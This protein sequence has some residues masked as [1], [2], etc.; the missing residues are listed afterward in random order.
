MKMKRFLSSTF[1]LLSVVFPLF[2]EVS[3]SDNLI[4]NGDF[5]LN[6]IGVGLNLTGPDGGRDEGQTFSK[7]VFY[8]VGKPAVASF[9][10][11][12]VSAESIKGGTAGGHA[13]RLDIDAGNSPADFDYGI[14]RDVGGGS[15]RPRVDPETQ[16]TLAFDLALVA[17]TG[18]STEFVATVY[19]FSDDEKEFIRTAC[20]KLG[21]A[22]RSLDDDAAFH[23]YAMNFTTSPSTTKVSVSLSPRV[24]GGNFTA[25][26]VLANVSLMPSSG[27][28][29]NTT[30]A[31]QV[32]PLVA[33]QGAAPPPKDV[34]FD[35][36]VE[37]RLSSPYGAVFRVRQ[38]EFLSIAP[39]IL[40][41]PASAEHKYHGWMAMQE[42]L[43]WETNP[44]RFGESDEADGLENSLGWLTVE[45]GWPE[46]VRSRAG[47][48]ECNTGLKA[49]DYDPFQLSYTYQH[50]KI[51]I[52]ILDRPA[53]AVMAEP[54]A[55][56]FYLGN[57]NRLKPHKNYWIAKSRYQDA[58]IFCGLVFCNPDASADNDK[59]VVADGVFICWADSIEELDELAASFS[60]VKSILESTKRWITKLTDPVQLKGD[61][62]LV[63]S[64]TAIRRGYLSMSYPFG[65][66]Y[67][68]LDEY[69]NFWVRDSSVAAVFTALS[70]IGGPLAR[71]TPYV[72]N[73]PE[74]VNEE[75][76]ESLS[77]QTFPNGQT[78]KDETDGPFY[79]ALDVYANWKLN[80]D[81]QKLKDWYPIL[82][83]AVDHVRR[84]SFDPEKH[85]FMDLWVG[86]YPACLTK[87]TRASWKEA[88]P[89][90]P[91]GPV[92][93]SSMYQNTIVCQTYLMLAEMALTLGKDE[94]SAGYLASA[95]EL[96]AAMD[97]HLWKPEKG[98]Y[99]FAIRKLADG[100]NE[101]LE[102]DY[103]C[104]GYD[105]WV[106]LTAGFPVTPDPQK[107]F[108]TV[109]F[110]MNRLFS[111]FGKPSGKAFHNAFAV[112]HAARDFILAGDFQKGRSLMN[113]AT[114]NCENQV[115]YIT[116]NKMNAFYYM[117]GVFGERLDVHVHLPFAW[118]SGVYMADVTA[119]IAPMD[120]NGITIMPTPYLKE[121][122]GLEF[123]NS[124][125]A[126]ST[127]RPESLTDK[128]SSPEPDGIV[129]DGKPVPHTM[130][131]PNA[132]LKEGASHRVTLL[133]GSKVGPVLRYTPFELVS[134]KAD[135]ECIKYRLSGYGKG[136]LRFNE[137]VKQQMIQ[138][139]D[140]CGKN[141]PFDFWT[142]EG[143]PCIGVFGRG[144]FVVSIA[145]S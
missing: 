47:N 26:V 103:T 34:L 86:E 24:V 20:L 23:R 91:E 68:G 78:F 19:E 15:G 2:G 106:S 113:I 82:C 145:S 71:W 101:E 35:K 140:S 66:T 22:D 30:M 63:K 112:A 74:P 3:E 43:G 80:G 56:R 127:E 120:F 27:S 73:N 76:K 88:W 142:S 5:E 84:I 32:A 13:V 75:G 109:D 6:E 57:K 131:I 114:E 125:F 139:R 17:T 123:R 72:M 115:P 110:M 94:E 51:T 59:S 48:L 129:L 144:P 119:L 58:D 50:G 132:L 45:T 12:I 49:I 85:L 141:M 97:K 96:A 14:N 10:G 111:N 53:I 87:E 102:Q 92:A 100:R 67:A 1:V 41:R 18:D 121:I 61:A 37:T 122:R 39:G 44:T 29:A 118:G 77:F 134:L 28:G 133:Y 126:V 46:E 65:G 69:M 99:L 81:K 116:E 31:T 108:Q 42:P 90:E 70:G 130:K 21:T 93:F 104:K 124:V 55:V 138:I 79:A 9:Q 95:E 83:S 136:V 40:P 36:P 105:S 137:C 107:N 11:T 8:S 135:S 64:Y 143:G 62:D 16:Y 7:W 117:K 52:S 54:G 25:S 38:A 98:H 60:D 4:T 128:S 89:E 33:R